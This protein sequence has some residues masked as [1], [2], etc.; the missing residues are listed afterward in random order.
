MPFVIAG[1][2]AGV[3]QV[4]LLKKIPARLPYHFQEHFFFIL[5]FP[6]VL[7]ETNLVLTTMT[8]KTMLGLKATKRFKRRFY[9]LK[10]FSQ[11]FFREETTFQMLL[12]EISMKSYMGLM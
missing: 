10:N 8:V 7:M 1:I 6:T 4:Y 9:G 2:P 12:M 11:L 3:E 5:L